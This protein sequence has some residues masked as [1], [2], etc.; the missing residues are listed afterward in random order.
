MFIFPLGMNAIQYWIIDNFIMDKKKESKGGY[1]AVGEDDDDEENGRDADEQG[2]V[3]EVGDDVDVIGSKQVDHAPLKEVNPTPLNAEQ[4]RVLGGRRLSR[5]RR[6]RLVHEREDECWLCIPCLGRH[7]WED[8]SCY[9][10]SD[11]EHTCLLSSI[12]PGIDLGSPFARS[13]P[14]GRSC[15]TYLLTVTTNHK[16]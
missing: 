11:H 15:A 13:S 6:R 14:H 5:T 2:S 12:V 9:D 16:M 7:D 3:T 10:V 8:M 1:E 4:V